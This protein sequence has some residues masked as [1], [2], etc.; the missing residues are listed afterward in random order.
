MEQGPTT[1]M[2]RSS[3]PCSTSE[4]AARLVST[5][6]CAASG[7]GNHSCSRAGVI[8]GRTALMRR[9]SMR[10]SEEHTSELQSPCNLVC[11]LL[12][13]KKN[14]QLTADGIYDTV[15]LVAWHHWQP[16]DR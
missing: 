12:L 8:R 2:S 5:S 1:T 16:R 15:H 14:T 3:R 10:R 4:M 9:S 6:C 13:E 11:R 7:A